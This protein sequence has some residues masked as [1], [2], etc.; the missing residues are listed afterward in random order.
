MSKLP[1]SAWKAMAISFAIFLGAV[2]GLYIYYLT[3]GIE[4]AAKSTV[5]VSIAQWAAF[6][7]VVTS[8]PAWLLLKLKETSDC[9]TFISALV[10]TSIG[11]IIT[12]SAFALFMVLPNPGNPIGG[13]PV[14]IF[15][16]QGDNLVPTNNSANVVMLF[17]IG[18][19]SL[20][21][22]SWIEWILWGTAPA[23]IGSNFIGLYTMLRGPSPISLFNGDIKDIAKA[24]RKLS[25]MSPNSAV[26]LL[27]RGLANDDNDEVRFNCANSLIPYDLT[28][29][30]I[31]LVITA[32]NDKSA[33]VRH[34]VVAFFG[35]RGSADR[36]VHQVIPKL[37]HL[38]LIPNISTSSSSADESIAVMMLPNAISA[39]LMKTV[40]ANHFMLNPEIKDVSA[41]RSILNNALHDEDP[42]VRQD[43]AKYIE[44][45][46]LG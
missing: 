5:L 16:L 40:G 19:I 22:P 35:L 7:S 23:I 11:A 38:L 45:L 39:A 14:E 26:D 44:A 27:L 12:G 8:T 6:L 18:I 32:L 37:F 46:E 41:I 10:G 17:Y 3:I 15:Q 24:M 1:K 29:D 36:P 20:T 25:R 21:L 42:G 4:G 43:A 9:G 2:S 30:Q 33:K 34:S 28:D 31:N 13:Y